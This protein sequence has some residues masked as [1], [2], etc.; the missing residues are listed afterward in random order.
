MKKLLLKVKKSTT[1]TYGAKEVVCPIVRSAGDIYT[2][3]NVCIL[4]YGDDYE[5]VETCCLQKHRDIR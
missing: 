4:Y 3:P 2:C 1:T 5:E